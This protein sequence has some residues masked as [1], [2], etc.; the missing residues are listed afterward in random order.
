MKFKLNDYSAGEAIRLIRDSL[1]ETQKEF[2]KRVKK[3]T[4]T[5]YRYETGQIDY[6][7]SFLYQLMKQYHLTITVEKKDPKK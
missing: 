7:I 6:K 1:D 3:T 4:N 2:G 5:I